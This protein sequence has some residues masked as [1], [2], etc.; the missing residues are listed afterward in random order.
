MYIG[1]LISYT[2]VVNDTALSL[3]PIRG[4]YTCYTQS[5]HRLSL[6]GADHHSATAGMDVQDLL[7]GGWVGGRHT[8]KH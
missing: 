2:V 6:S 1:V 7:M 4:I 5:V 8:V 3:P